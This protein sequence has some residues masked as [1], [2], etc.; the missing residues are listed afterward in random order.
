P[1]VKIVTAG[2][3]FTLAKMIGIDLG[4]TPGTATAVAK[5]IDG[6]QYLDVGVAGLVTT[7]L[8]KA[9]AAL[10]LLDPV[11]VLL[12]NVIKGLDLS[13]LDLIGIRVPITIGFGLGAFSLGQAYNQIVTNL[14]NQPGGLDDKGAN[15]LGSLTIMP[16]ILLNNLGRANGGLLARFYPVGDLLGINT[17]TPDAQ[18]AHSGSGLDVLGTGISLGAANIL[19]VKVDAT[20]EY[21]PFSDFAAWPDPFSLLNNLVA[22]T[23]PTYL[24]RGIS[25]NTLTSQLESALGAITGG[26]LGNKALAANIYLTIPTATLP[27]LEPLYLAG[28]VAN[29]VSFGTL[30]GFF[31]RLANAL[32]PALTSL[33]NLGYTDV[34]RNSDGT[35]SRTLDSAGQAV[36]FFSF[37]N[38]NWSRVPGDILHDLQVGLQKQFSATPTAAPPNIIEALV[39]LLTGGKVKLGFNP[40]A[41]PLA[42]VGK[43]LSTLIGDLTGTL[44]GLT[45]KTTSVAAT[46]AAALPAAT[47]KLVALPAASA[48]AVGDSA[49]P[50]GKAGAATKADAADKT[51]TADKTDK[52]MKSSGKHAAADDGT[53]PVDSG[54]APK[55]ALPD[56]SD[57]AGTTSPVKSSGGKK[58]GQ[59]DGQDVPSLKVVHDATSS[60]AGSVAASAADAAKPGAK[61]SGNKGNPGAHHGSSGNRAGGHAA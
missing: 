24:L 1:G 60:V 57:S 38:L 51:D 33:V 56:S 17:I 41:G 34:V 49:H 45:A 48:A 7:V 35:Y 3:L 47:N 43:I 58:S 46:H 4:W 25:T 53:A 28:D 54:K 2:P 36:P 30:G 16:E 5:A 8:S 9:A 42:A 15:L 20:L 44:R 22:G 12:E 39:S 50:A 52:A 10:P 18:A 19:P 37:P 61:A 13:K 21:Q 14:A 11:V 29:M 31:T 59:K 40:L 55:H 26:I 6:T 27:L 32:S 23:L